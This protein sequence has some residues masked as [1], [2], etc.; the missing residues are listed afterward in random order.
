MIKSTKVNNTVLAA[1][2]DYA[3]QRDWLIF[4]ARFKLDDKTGKWEKK[5]WKSA[6]TSN[7]R[8]WGMTQDPAE[9][10]RDFAKPG[11]SAVGVPTGAVNNI[12]VVEADTPSG[13]DVDGLASLKQLEAE[14]GALP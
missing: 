7:G 1:A 12:F 13:H 2:L 8:P 11:R 6:K 5:S 3:T 14:H 4:P 9:I 10:R